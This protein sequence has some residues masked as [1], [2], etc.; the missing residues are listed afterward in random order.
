MTRYVV[1]KDRSGDCAAPLKYEVEA[2][3]LE[4]E[5]GALKFSVSRLHPVYGDLVY[6]T[7]IKAIAPGHWSHVD[8][9]DA[10]APQ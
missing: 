8:A 10:E 5:H 1:W 3:K 7:V 2:D 4:V 9:L 6:M